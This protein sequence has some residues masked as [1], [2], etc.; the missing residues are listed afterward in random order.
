MVT[1]SHFEER[2]VLRRV[3]E[4]RRLV[5]LVVFKKAAS[6]LYFTEYLFSRGRDCKLSPR[7]L[8]LGFAFL[9]SSSFC[10]NRQPS[11]QGEGYRLEPSGAVYAYVYE[12]G[13]E[14]HSLALRWGV[15]ILTRGRVSGWWW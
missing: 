8:H 7:I 12:I 15:G 9:L 1:A 11:R 3:V 6:E 13:R 5:G 14:A 2:F 10:L 4:G